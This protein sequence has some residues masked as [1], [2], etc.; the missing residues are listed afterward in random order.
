MKSARVDYGG[1]YY[2]SRPYI[3]LG[4]WSCCAVFK[5][6]SWYFVYHNW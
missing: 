4:K 1:Q 2:W 6:L 3:S 5:Y